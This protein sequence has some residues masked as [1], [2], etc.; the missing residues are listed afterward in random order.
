MRFF[1][2]TLPDL[3]AV[4]AAELR[5]SRISLTDVIAECRAR[6]FAERVATAADRGRAL[7]SFALPHSRAAPSGRTRTIVRLLAGGVPVAV[8]AERANL[9]ERQLH[10]WS[11]RHFG[12]GPKTLARILRFRRA[13]RL[14]GGKSS[15]ATI[16]A[17][18]GYADQAHLIRE[19]RDLAGASFAALVS[20]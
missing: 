5:D 12:Y 1:P 11:M 3:L 7:E 10:R 2:G 20:S 9:S 17:Q 6:T 4:S 8:V 14:A 13:M 16:A 15:G 18:A 19:A